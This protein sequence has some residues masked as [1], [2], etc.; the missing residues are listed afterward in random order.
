MHYS[1]GAWQAVLSKDSQAHGFILPAL[2]NTVT[3]TSPRPREVGG[4]LE[5]GTAQVVGQN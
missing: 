5:I 1:R 2:P 4:G 3:H